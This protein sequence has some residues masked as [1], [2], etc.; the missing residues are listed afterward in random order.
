[1]NH[2]RLLHSYLNQNHSKGDTVSILR[3]GR[4]LAPDNINVIRTHFSKLIKQGH[5]EKV[6]ANH[7]KILSDKITYEDNPNLIWVESEQGYQ[8]GVQKHR[9]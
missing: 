5:V 1:M 9:N 4:T 3:I 8:I 7:Y 2:R 6:K